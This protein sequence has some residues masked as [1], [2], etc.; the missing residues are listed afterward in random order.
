MFPEGSEF[1]AAHHLG[2]R[3]SRD[4]TIN[5]HLL[6]SIAD[7]LEVNTLATAMWE[8]N[9]RPEFKA[10]PRPGV[11][12]EAPQDDS[13]TTSGRSLKDLYQSFAGSR[14]GKTL[15]PPAKKT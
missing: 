3:E 1:D 11:K 4:W 15:P 12:T 6:A 14:P 7:R 5:T 9:K 8:K 10:I 2:S 13:P